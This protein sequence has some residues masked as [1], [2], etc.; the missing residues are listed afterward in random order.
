MQAAVETVNFEADALAVANENVPALERSFDYR[1]IGAQPVFAERYPY[2][3]PADLAGAVA[4]ANT[5]HYHRNHNHTADKV[6]KMARFCA[7]FILKR[8]TITQNVMLH[9]G[10]RNQYIS[11]QFQ[12]DNVPR[13]CDPQER[14]VVSANT[15][16]VSGGHS[17]NMDG[18]LHGKSWQPAYYFDNGTHNNRAGKGGLSNLNSNNLKVRYYKHGDK[19]RYA[20]RLQEEDVKTGTVEKTRI[21]RGPIEVK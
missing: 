8:P 5:S 9:P 4:M 18:P 17:I 19:V 14:R 13:V 15:Q 10:K 2:G 7:P 12:L 1:D 20:I 21:Y 6:S 16:L 11:L 3:N